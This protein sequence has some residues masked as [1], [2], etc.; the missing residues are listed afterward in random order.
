[1]ET[2]DRTGGVG[3]RGTSPASPCHGTYSTKLQKGIWQAAVDWQ[4]VPIRN[5]SLA[6][7]P[8][9]VL[10]WRKNIWQYILYFGGLGTQPHAACH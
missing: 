6:R 5:S 4:Y 9:R 3:R 10:A 2:N 8:R 7:C 1:M